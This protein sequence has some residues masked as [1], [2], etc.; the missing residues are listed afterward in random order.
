MTALRLALSALGTFITYSTLLFGSLTATVSWSSE[1]FPPKFAPA[2]SVSKEELEKLSYE[3]Q[4]LDL[5]H[6]HDVGLVGDAGSQ[7]DDPEFFLSPDGATNPA[8]ELNASIAA[9]AKADP[10]HAQKRCAYP[11]RFF[12]LKSKLGSEYF[13]SKTACPEFETWRA[14]LSADGLTLIFP[15]AYLNSP[16]SMFGHTLMRL[17]SSNSKSELLAYSINYAANADPN[18]NELVFSYKGLTGGYPG[19]FSVLPYYEKVKEYNYLESRDVWEYELDITPEE[20][21]QFVRHVWEVK[22]AH[23]DYYFFTENCSYHLL[24]LLDAAS[25][26]FELSKEFTT[27]VIPADTVRVLNEKELIKKASFRPSMQTTLQHRLKSS[28]DETEALAIA[29][30]ENLNTPVPELLN[31]SSLAAPEKAQ[32]LELSVSLARYKAK[33]DKENASEYNK[34]SIRLLSARSKLGNLETFTATPTPRIRDDEGHRSHRWM[35]RAGEDQIG[36]YVGLDLRMSYHDFLDPVAGYIPGAQLEIIHLKAKAYTDKATLQIEEFRAID[37]ASFSPRDDFI[38]PIS[39]FVST[40]LTRNEHQ[41]DELMPYLKA[42]PGLSYSFAS[43]SGASLIGSGLLSTR[44]F[45][46]N[47]LDKGFVLESGP[48]VQFSLQ[49][50]ELS[51]QAYWERHYKL[52]GAD[53]D[54]QKA[55]LGVGHG[56]SNSTS[57]RAGASYVETDLD[58]GARLYDTS[59]ELGFAWYF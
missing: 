27:D 21:E 7:I 58:D 43:W 2:E 39:W 55:F 31:E 49:H 5:L 6:Y 53:I 52:A 3:R 28:G 54:Q 33:Q 32:A 26:R 34:R 38:K 16:S 19:V 17:D 18:D 23:F 37:I 42:G 47:D 13:G 40:G 45:A 35:A 36:T 24:T 12:W 51:V 22:D 8:A 29:L 15:A 10:E 11:A 25:E 30:V 48:K 9:F 46:D 56:I 44:V 4:W 20:L 57:I 41:I 59:G 1:S 50:T 14:E